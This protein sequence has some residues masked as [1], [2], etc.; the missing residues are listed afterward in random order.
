MHTMYH[1][2]LTKVK[3]TRN[4]HTT[5]SLVESFFSKKSLRLDIKQI[6]I[7]SYISTISI[8]IIITDL[9]RSPCSSYLISHNSVCM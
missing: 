9:F 7:Q 3:S 8:V 1:A 4:S 6:I 5:D 2:V